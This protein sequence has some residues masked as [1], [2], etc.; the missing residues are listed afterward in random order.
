MPRRVRVASLEVEKNGLEG[1][2]H[3]SQDTILVPA[4]A[5]LPWTIKDQR[6]IPIFVAW[7]KMFV[8]SGRSEDGAIRQ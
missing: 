8:A 4:L 3:R 2:Y 5:A 6:P 7:T 1:K